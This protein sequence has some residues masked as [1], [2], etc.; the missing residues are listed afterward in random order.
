MFKLESKHKVTLSSNLNIIQDLARDYL[1]KYDFI[2]TD[3]NYIATKN[4]MATINKEKLNFKTQ[5]DVFLSEILKPITEFK[6]IQK[7]IE[8]M[9]SNKR[10]ILAEEVKSIDSTKLEVIKDKLQAYLTEL[11]SVSKV[12]YSLVDLDKYVKLSA[13]ST[14]GSISLKT[15]ELLVNEVFILSLHNRLNIESLELIENYNHKK[16]TPKK[17]TKLLDEL[18][19]R[20]YFKGTKNE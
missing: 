13:V 7:E 3:S 20:N 15:K 2:V 10:S 12:D 18:E 1:T 11:C 6:T 19:Q 5:C 9:F 17:L 14:Q 16:S 4:T 8:D